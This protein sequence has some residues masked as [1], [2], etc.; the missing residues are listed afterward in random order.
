MWVMHI[1]VPSP[2]QNCSKCCFRKLPFKHLYV[3]VCKCAYMCKVEWSACICAVCSPG[4]IHKNIQ[5]MCCMIL[6]YQRKQMWY[7]LISHS[8]LWSN[9]NLRDPAVAKHLHGISSKIQISTF[10]QSTVGIPVFSLCE[11][12]QVCVNYWGLFF[13]KHSPPLAAHFNLVE[14]VIK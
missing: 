5:L 10:H 7:L 14:G 12:G 11:W 2:S 9:E 3:C 4:E 6:I 8:R 13:F 1:T